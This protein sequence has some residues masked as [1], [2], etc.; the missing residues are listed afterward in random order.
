MTEKNNERRISIV[1]G[2]DLLEAGYTSVPNLLLNYYARLGMTADELVFVVHLLQHKWSEK[3]PFPRLQTIAERMGK[4]W[5][6]VH[7]YAQSLK[8]KCLLGITNRVLK[9]RGM[10]TSE[11]DLSPLFLAIQRAHRDSTVPDSQTA[12]SKLSGGPPDKTDRGHLSTLS[13]VEEYED[14]EYEDINISKRKNLRKKTGEKGE[15]HE[16]VGISGQ[17][18]AGVT[19]PTR[20][21]ASSQP[22]PIS[23]IVFN[24]Y[25][26]SPNHELSEA[27]EAIG[28]YIAGFSAQFS[29]KATLKASTSRAYHLFERSQTTLSVFLSVLYEAGRRCNEYTATTPGIGGSSAH[30]S[31]PKHQMAYFFAIVEQL[32]HFRDHGLSAAGPTVTRMRT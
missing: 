22:T 23:Q 28:D 20:A 4:S 6:Q 30:T 27:R 24:R 25:K 31:P 14:K 15:S 10:T 9:G 21:V 26:P 32:L 1:F 13:G 29:D 7:R 17:Q 5:R 3:D 16:S 8:K 2:D 11:Y 18:L 12:L 19:K